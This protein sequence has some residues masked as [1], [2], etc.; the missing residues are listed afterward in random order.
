MLFID[1]FDK[2]AELFPERPFLVEGDREWT[3]ADLAELTYRIA[4]GLIAAGVESGERVATWA[5]NC[6][7]AYACQWGVIR[8][9]A[10]WMPMN[11]R[12]G[13][14]ENTEIL[15]RMDCRF[16]FFHDTL[17]D[18]VVRVLEDLPQVRGAVCVNNSLPPFASLT[19]WMPPSRD[20]EIG[21][22]PR[23]REDV[24]MLPATSGTTGQPKGVMLTHGN[25]E[26]MMANYQSIMHYDVEPV[27]LAVA[28][29]THGAGYF[30]ATLIPQ[31]GTIVMLNRTDPGSIL[32]AIERHRVT[33]V[34][35]P[36]TL[37]YK[38]LAHPGVREYDY[39][40]LRYVIYGAAP[41]SVEKLREAIDVFGPVLTENYS[42]TECPVT[43]AVL[44]PAEHMEAL[45]NPDLEHR[46]LSTGRP[47]PFSQVA[48][49]DDDGTLLP[50]GERGEIVVRGETVMKGYL[51]QPEETEKVSSYGW[52]HTGDIGVID[53]DRYLYVVDRKKDMIISGG[54]NVYPSE[55][56]Q[57]IWGH[58]AV[59]DCAVVG[60]PDERWGE[61]V[62]AVIELQ[63]GAS[64]DVD[65]FEAELRQQ[66]GGVKAP[67]QIFVWETLPRSGNGKVLKREIRDTFWTAQPRRI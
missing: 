50:P 60:A 34:F 12:N 41:M 56:E 35:F 10:V 1:F 4:D 42:Q 28:P 67:K 66:L 21:Y 38:L 47:A 7:L 32:E 14:R 51:D 33:T 9:G 48:I 37:L 20:P 31:G 46:L 15:D 24:V 30:A 59:Q 22:H 55:V 44:T 29:L 25:W 3:F 53:D 52:H 61:V 36:P 8:A 18:D 16:L 54:F 40:S 17:A 58:P 43:V 63:D 26:A 64:I 57:V 6:A 11:V 19:E 5:P 45:S 13:V 23:T 62:T 27:T 49:M 39:S 65:E 2:G